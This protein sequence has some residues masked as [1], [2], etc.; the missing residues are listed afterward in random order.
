[1]GDFAHEYS[2]WR[3]QINVEQYLEEASY[4]FFLNDISTVS[5]PWHVLFEIIFNALPPPPPP[6]FPK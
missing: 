6:L 2:Q 1:M 5:D 4:L 3:Q